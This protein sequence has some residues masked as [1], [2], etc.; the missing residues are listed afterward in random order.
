M[1]TFG[2]ILTIISSS[3]I[4]MVLGMLVYNVYR[5]V[6]NFLPQK[7][8]RPRISVHQ[9]REIEDDISIFLEAYGLPRNSSINEI[10][11]RMQIPNHNGK[12]R[13][14][15]NLLSH[16]CTY[17]VDSDFCGLDSTEYTARA[18]LMPL[19]VMAKEIEDSH[20]DIINTETRINFI[21][22]LCSKFRTDELNVLK[23]IGEV[24][25]LKTAET[26]DDEND[27]EE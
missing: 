18:L 10:A 15:T 5:I 11:K 25:L 23:R 4:S 13:K 8:A 6:K 9:M 24:I 21:K 2:I 14:E 12:S 1:K 20:Y 3:I 27:D 22:T 26:N 19:D 16:R 17:F 7:T